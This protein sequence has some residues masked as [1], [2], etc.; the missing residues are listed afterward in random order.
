MLAK[1][2]HQVRTG[3]RAE[4]YEQ[5]AAAGSQQSLFAL[6]PAQRGE[7]LDK[8]VVSRRYKKRVSPSRSW[9]DGLCVLPVDGMCKAK[10]ASA[11]TASLRTAE[12]PSQG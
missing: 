5:R 11:E 9:R 8:P 1:H 10:T 6:G 12:F 7:E 4:L 2:S 3:K